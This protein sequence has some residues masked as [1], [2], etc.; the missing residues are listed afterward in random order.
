MDAVE[1]LLNFLERIE[2]GLDENKICDKTTM[3]SSSTKIEASTDDSDAINQSYFENT[4]VV[5]EEPLESKNSDDYVNSI[6]ENF[7]GQ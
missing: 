6:A 5:E 4:E 3:S 2:E 1:Y 7:F